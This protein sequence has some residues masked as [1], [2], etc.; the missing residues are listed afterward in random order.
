[1]EG[2]QRQRQRDHR[3]EP[4]GLADARA[5]TRR[6]AADRAQSTSTSSSETAASP[7]IRRASS[8]K[9]SG[10]SLTQK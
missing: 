9:R 5:T 6:V 1:M 7:R 2:E 10:P 3:D 4:Q 8:P